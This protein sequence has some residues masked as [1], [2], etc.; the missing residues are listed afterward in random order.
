MSES[1]LTFKELQTYI[2]SQL[3]VA[4]YGATGTEVAQPPT[5]VPTAQQIKDYVNGGIRTF[6][7]D[8]PEEGWR[9]QQPIASLVLW[10]S[11]TTGVVTISGVGDTTAT[12]ASSDFYAS[13]VGHT[14][15]ASTSG[16]TYVITA[17]TSAT[18]V[19]LSADASADTGDTF[20]LTA[21]GNYT[22]PSDFGG[23]YASK[24]T[25]AAST[26]AGTPIKWSNEG[27]VRRLRENTETQTGYPSLAATRKMDATNIARRWEM[28]VYPTP[29]GDYTVQF[30]YELH[31]TALTSDGDLHP[32]GANYDE[33]IKTACAAFAELHG[34][35]ALSGRQQYY[36]TVA[37]PA[38][39]RI[40]RRSAPKSLGN[41][42]PKEFNITDWRDLQERPDVTTF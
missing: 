5:D 20:T 35:D 38:A 3:G 9:V 30:A 11:K 26:N 33:V 27:T 17:Y 19:T 31:F 7:M 16:N 10:A 4:Y 12:S 36:R 34:E 1:A 13:M 14:I 37:L 40:N 25:Y 29:G 15:T 24:L 18:V 32:F 21:T 2:A 28:V 22:L 6:L 8:A 42:R 23:E 41:L 39:Y